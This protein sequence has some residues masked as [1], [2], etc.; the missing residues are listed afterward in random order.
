[1]VKPTILRYL[2]LNILNRLVDFWT[3]SE[4]IAGNDGRS[5]EK[6]ADV[7]KPMLRL[8]GLDASLVL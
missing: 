7:L 3:K 2:A 5:G 6:P 4:N 8:Y 1:M